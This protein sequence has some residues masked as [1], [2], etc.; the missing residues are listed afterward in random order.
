M[1]RM[2]R[3]GVGIQI[4]N[5]VRIIV[6]ENSRAGRTFC[7]HVVQEW[8]IGFIILQLIGSGCLEC[9]AGNSEVLSV[10]NRKEGC[11]RLVMSAVFVGLTC[12]KLFAGCLST[13][14]HAAWS[15]W[16]APPAPTIIFL[17]GSFFKSCL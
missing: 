3:A 17:A 10:F 1:W 16:N 11:D 6:L 12:A 7:N 13:F 9:C 14:T 8:Q 4:L 15:L 5:A 2:F